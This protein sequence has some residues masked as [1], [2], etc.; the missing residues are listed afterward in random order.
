VDLRIPPGGVPNPP[1]QP[2]PADHR[3]SRSTSN[4]RSQI[5]TESFGVVIPTKDNNVLRLGFQNIGG[6]PVDKS[7]QKEDTIFT[8]ISMWSVNIFGVAETNLDWRLLP[9]DSKLHTRTKSWWTSLHISHAFNYT[10]PP[11]QPLQYG[12]TA[13]FSINKAAHR[14]MDKGQDASS[15]GRW[16]WTKYRGRNGHTLRVVSAYRPNPPQGPYS[17]YAQHSLH[18]RSTRDS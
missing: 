7:K 18:L 15:L 17:V 8:G 9:E 16:C 12:G 13:I 5:S 14:V 1:R 4:H 10:R 11:I 3:D 2:G 6:F